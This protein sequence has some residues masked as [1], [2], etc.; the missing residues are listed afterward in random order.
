MVPIVRLSDS[1]GQG[2]LM[3][4]CP[5]HR[6]MVFPLRKGRLGA[7]SDWSQKSDYLGDYPI[8]FES[9]IVRLLLSDSVRFTIKDLV[10]LI[11]LAQDPHFC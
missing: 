7:E 2:H 1:K 3:S 6:A 8:Q 5:I 10:F 4:D 9:P 11:D